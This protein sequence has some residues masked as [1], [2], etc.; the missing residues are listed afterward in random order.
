MTTENDADY[1]D[2]IM[3]VELRL[4]K[5][6]EKYSL[7]LKPSVLSFSL[8]LTQIELIEKLSNIRKLLPF[9]T[10]TIKNDDTEQFSV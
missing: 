7:H 4:K 2:E 3:I 6:Y 5:I 9:R 1:F 8:V 10:D